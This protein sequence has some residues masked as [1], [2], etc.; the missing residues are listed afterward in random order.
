M[1]QHTLLVKIPPRS[2][3][4]AKRTLSTPEHENAATS[5]KRTNP[6]AC[7]KPGPGVEASTAAPPVTEGTVLEAV[8]WG[9]S[10]MCGNWLV[11]D[12]AVGRGHAGLIK[13]FPRRPSTQRSRCERRVIGVVDHVVRGKDH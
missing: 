6:T 8:W 12:C 9:R 3:V 5:H 13:R 1:S 2:G 10:V 7:A 4:S 11:D